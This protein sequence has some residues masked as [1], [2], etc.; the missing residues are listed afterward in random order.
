M[1]KF[2]T[3]LVMKDGGAHKFSGTY[4]VQLVYTPPPPKLA[5]NFESYTSE[6]FSSTQIRCVSN[7]PRPV[8][9]CVHSCVC[10]ILLHSADS[11]ST[12][13][14]GKWVSRERYIICTVI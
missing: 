14:I 3:L 11:L 8:C 2:P 6:H 10:V 7:F 12:H 1:T 9:V 13:N 4:T 5:L